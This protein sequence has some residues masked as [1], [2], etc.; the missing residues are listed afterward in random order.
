[1]RSIVAVAVAL[2]ALLSGSATTTG[3]AA[4]ATE[5]KRDL[6]LD[7]NGRAGPTPNLASS[8]SASVTTA[9]A[10]AGGGTIVGVRHRGQGRA[11]RLERFAT[12]SPGLAVL[13]VRPKGEQDPFAPGDKAFTF[14]AAFRLDARNEGSSVDNG[15]N[16]VQRGLYADDAQFKV[17][18]DGER[19]SCRVSGSAG[20]VVVTARSDLAPRRWHRARC[21]RKADSVIL[22]LVE[23][24]ADGVVKRRWTRSGT[25]GE[26][27]FADAPPLAVGGKVD[28]SGE[29]AAGDSDQFNG[30]VDNVFFR[31]LPG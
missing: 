8:G 15:N 23:R 1:M 31:R 24:T 5:P 20:S 22:R 6:F 10:S 25:I 17:Q 16:L 9:I 28:S 21:T 4:A 3:A 14:G 11:A 2:T 18:V 29:V 19:L 30:R 13:V 26:L 12:D 27:S 7:F